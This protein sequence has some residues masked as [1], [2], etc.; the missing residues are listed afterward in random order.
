MDYRIKKILKN[1]EKNQKKC[2]LFEEQ[3]VSYMSTEQKDKKYIKINVWISKKHNKL[4]Q[5][6]QLLVYYFALK[7]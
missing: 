6:K 2:W 7:N 3:M 4:R 1:I 5:F